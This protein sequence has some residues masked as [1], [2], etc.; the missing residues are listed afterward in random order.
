MTDV[1]TVVFFHAHPDDEAIFTG[2]TMA[3]LAHAGWTVVLV[4]ATGGEL[5]LAPVPLPPGADPLG[6]AQAHIVE[7]RMAETQRAAGLLG[8]ARVEFLGYHDSGMAGDPANEWPGSFWTSETEAVARRLADLLADVGAGALVVYDEA[9]IYGHPDHVQVHRAGIRAA[10]LAGIDI[11]YECT[12]DREYL[13]FVETHLVAEAGSG[14][15]S[16]SGS[17]TGAG[18]E[19]G[20]GSLGLAASPVGV[21]TVLVSTTVDVRHVLHLKRAAM[22]AHASQIPETASAMRLPAEAFGAVYG[23]EWFV[24]RGVSGPIETL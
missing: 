21:P 8:V 14:S 12:V 6:G 1:G 23:Y 15:G 18:N 11:V 7:Q 20:G 22:A 16:G 13:H 3:R 2:G 5:G 19:E 10:E 17:W 4:V 9:G 24:R